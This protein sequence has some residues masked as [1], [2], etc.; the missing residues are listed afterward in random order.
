[1]A[2]TE[3]IQKDIEAFG[4]HFSYDIS[5]LKKILLSS[6]VAFDAYSPVQEMS[7]IR[8][9]LPLDAHFVARIVTMQADDCGACT[10][11]NLRMAVQAGVSRE[12]LTTL[13]HQPEHLPARLGDV[14]VHVLS[15]LG[16]TP[17]DP[18]RLERLTE[19]YGASGVSEMA[20]IIAGSIVYPTLKRALGMQ[21]ACEKPHLDF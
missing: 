5:Y 6:R 8:E 15:A 20:V 10:Q 16:Q 13:L 3:E 1:M 2:S 21:T 9:S 18:D 17:P 19:A 4:Q 11:L 7:S 12:L 14:R